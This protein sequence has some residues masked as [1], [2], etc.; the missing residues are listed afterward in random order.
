MLE[1]SCERKKSFNKKK[2]GLKDLCTTY[3]QNKQ[4]N[5]VTYQNQLFK[6]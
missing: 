5:N 6:L 4:L 3:R 2:R 1:T